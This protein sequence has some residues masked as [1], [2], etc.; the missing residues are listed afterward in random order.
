M[1]KTFLLLLVVSNLLGY[2][3]VI[4]SSLSKEE[5]DYLFPIKDKYGNT[6]KKVQSPYT[7]RTW[8]DRNL[9][10]SKVCDGYN[11]KACYGDYFQWGRDA[12]GH[13][14]QNSSTTTSL[15]SSDTPNHSKF[16]MINNSP[17]DWRSAQND[18]LW[19]GLNG[20][21]NPCPK[22]FRI[23]T[24]NELEIETIRQGVKN[25]NDAYRNFLKLPSAGGRYRRNASVDNQGSW[26]YLWSSSLNGKY[27]R[28]LRFGSD[29]VNTYD[30][31]RAYGFSVHCLKD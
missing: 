1:K 9:G 13:E 14:K 19:Q 29:N 26:G 30:T 6:Y 22:G 16:I 28:Y 12:D 11:D 20:K 7:G 15:S 31:Y 18:N 5:L 21:N 23:P 25:S 27:A 24:I 2:E 10:A 3:I 8:L 17:Y 4:D